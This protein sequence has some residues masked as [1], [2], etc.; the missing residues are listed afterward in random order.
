MGI[1]GQQTTIAARPHYVTLS[2]P[3]PRIPNG[4]GG[5]TQPRIALNP[6]EVWAA[7]KPAT[8]SDL[9]KLAA[10]TVLS[11][12]T[13]IATFPFHPEV[14]TQT[15]LTWTDRLGAHTANVTG[16]SSPEQRGV[17]TI[18]ICVEVVP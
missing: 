7:I 4:H 18:A 8:V 10:G 14:T 15:Q 11:M 3:G 16:V 1:L 5:F 13:K 12:A 6:P 2:N 9:E 17:D